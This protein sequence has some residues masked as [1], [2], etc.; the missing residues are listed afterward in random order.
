MSEVELN[1]N[2]QD[3]VVVSFQICNGEIEI[4]EIMGTQKKLVQKVK[5]KLSLLKIEEAYDEETLYGYKLTF[6]KI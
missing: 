1:E 4:T 6:D 2:N 5:R 3:F